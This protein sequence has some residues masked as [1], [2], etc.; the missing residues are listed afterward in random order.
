MN[1]PS[2]LALHNNFTFRNNI[3]PMTTQI[4]NKRKKKSNDN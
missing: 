3:S 1:C 2:I 4:K